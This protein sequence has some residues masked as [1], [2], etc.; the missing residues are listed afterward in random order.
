MELKE[1]YTY[2]AKSGSTEVAPIVTL[3]ARRKNPRT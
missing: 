1:Y 3:T 2:N